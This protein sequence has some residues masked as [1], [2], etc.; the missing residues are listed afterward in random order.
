MMPEASVIIPAFNAAGTLAIQLEALA[1]QDD[2]PP[3]EVIVA[4]NGSK[5]GT[6]GVAESFRDRLDVRVI[7]A[8]AV[9]GPS[10]ARNAGAAAARS[11]FLLFCDAD[12]RVCDRWV[13]SM[14][15][16]LRAEGM[17]TG[18]VIYVDSVSD[19]PLPPLP[20]R[21]PAGPRRYL[22]QVPFATSNNLAVRADVF[23]ALGGFDIELACGEDAH[24]TIRAQV[25]GIRLAW[26]GDAVV[27]NA[28]R[29]T[30]K[31]TAVQFFRY[32]Y[33]QP[34][35]YRKLR[36]AGLSP[37]SPWRVVRPYLALVANV[38]RLFTPRRLSWVMNAA[39]RAGSLAGSVRFRVWCP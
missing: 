30:L 17:A 11:A 21:M 26:G 20:A 5:D 34:L 27:F 15:S 35:V 9:R 13:R 28:R 18:P 38:H 25:A 22:D 23:E 19:G 4:D 3:F 16:L 8:S 7:D 14:V 31:A 37:R 33:Y 10:F 2:A 6:R 12:D 32:G 24:F 29:P 1:T 39:Q 36:G